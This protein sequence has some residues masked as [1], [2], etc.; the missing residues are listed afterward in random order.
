[1]NEGDL[2]EAMIAIAVADST[3]VALMGGNALPLVEW[4]DPGMIVRP[5]STIQ[6]PDGEFGEGTAD[7]LE[8]VVQLDAFAEGGS[9][10]LVEQIL[11]RLEVI[12][13]NLNLT[14][15]GVDAAPLWRA[16][17]SLAGLAEG[18]R[19]KVLEGVILFNR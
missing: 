15:Q 2:Q 9:G 4:G 12:M 16:R 8:L 13:T 1:M 18:E 3:L 17:R 19:R 11:D 7:R 6:F 5:I 14:A 10:K